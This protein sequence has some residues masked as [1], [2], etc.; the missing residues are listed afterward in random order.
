MGQTREGGLKAAATNKARHG[1]D[2]YKKVGRIGGSRG[3]ADGV[4]KGFAAMSPEKHR[5][6]S[7]KGGMKGKRTKKEKKP[8]VWV[9]TDQNSTSTPS[10][11]K[12][13]HPCASCGE[14]YVVSELDDMGLCPNCP[15][16]HEAAKKHW[17]D[18]FKGV[19]RPF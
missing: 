18:R 11:M 9:A 19:Q 7:I 12:Q 13:M 2:F 5:Q 4:I 8:P 1:A 10:T 17:Y 6:A 15:V 16:E 14:T 3:K